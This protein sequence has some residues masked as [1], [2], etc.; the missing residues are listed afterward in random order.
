MG[1]GKY[2]NSGYFSFLNIDHKMDPTLAQENLD[3]ED[4]E[5][6]EHPDYGHINPDI[7]DVNDEVPLKSI[8]RKQLNLIYALMTNS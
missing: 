1:E 3:C 4:E 2:S 8:Y 7:V 5:I 6:V